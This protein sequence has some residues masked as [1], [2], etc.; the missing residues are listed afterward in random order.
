MKRVFSVLLLLVLL[1]NLSACK[2]AEEKYEPANTNSIVV[3][4]GTSSVVKQKKKENKKTTS[5]EKSNSSLPAHSSSSSKTVYTSS[6]VTEKTNGNYNGWYFKHLSVDQKKVYKII[7]TA[8]YNM[9]T[10]YINLGKVKYEDILLAFKS[11]LYDRPEYFWLSNEYIIKTNKKT[12]EYYIGFS[13]IKGEKVDYICNKKE[14]QIME[15]KMETAFSKIKKLCA[16]VSSD[17]K[18]RTYSSRLV[19]RTH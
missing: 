11:V 12:K 4:N 16:G 10:G 2:K 15:S 1:F 17:Y 6:K 5:S 9:K 8:V 18:K 3:E 7:D 14:R 19:N 13:E